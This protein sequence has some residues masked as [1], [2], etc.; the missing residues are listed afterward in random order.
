MRKYPAFTMLRRVAQKD[1]TV[2]NTNHVI[3]KGTLIIVPVYSIHR[4]PNYYPNPDVYDPERFTIDAEKSRHPMAWL[5]FGTGPRNCI[6]FKF[7]M[8]QFQIILI[9]LLRKFEV[10][11][12][13]NTMDPMVFKPSIL[14]LKPND[15]LYL[16]F[17]SL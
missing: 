12:C 14:L 7:A 13:E 11:V 10:T 8:T 4:D 9:T 3:E 17:K 15:K 6:A 1:Y 2:P 16:K 5:P